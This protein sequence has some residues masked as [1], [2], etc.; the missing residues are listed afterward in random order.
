M[1][2]A[3]EQT[4]DRIAFTGRKTDLTSV[5]FGRT[6]PTLN[7]IPYGCHAARPLASHGTAWW[8]IAGPRQIIERRFAHLYFLGGR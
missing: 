8:Y 2:A 7:E 5:I 6:A 3:L 1:D 4:L